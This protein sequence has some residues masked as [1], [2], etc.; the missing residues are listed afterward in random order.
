MWHLAVAENMYLLNVYIWILL[1]SQN[2]NLCKNILRSLMPFKS[3]SKGVFNL[4]FKQDEISHTIIFA[5]DFG[6]SELV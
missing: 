3:G 1:C 5:G 2:S 4:L 6:A